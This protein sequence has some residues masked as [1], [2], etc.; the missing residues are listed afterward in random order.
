M[1]LK[2]AVKRWPID[3]TEAANNFWYRPKSVHD[4]P[5]HWGT[6]YCLAISGLQYSVLLE[7][8][9]TPLNPRAAFQTRFNAPSIEWA[10]PFKIH[11][12]LTHL[13]F[14]NPCI[15]VWLR[16]NTNKMQLCN[17]IYY[18]KIYWRLNIFRA[19]HRSSSG[20]LNC[21]GSLWFIYPCGDR[22]LSRLGGNM[23]S[24]Q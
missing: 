1:I 20:A 24:L 7:T 2:N 13:I 23:F 12:L 8:W 4:R 10:P 11:I 17:R 19:A 3:R 22:L 21:I 9:S 18:S 15:V 16:R 5:K 6:I 14:M